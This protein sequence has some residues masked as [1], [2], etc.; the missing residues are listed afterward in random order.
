[1]L[2][3]GSGKDVLVGGAGEDSFVFTTT[4][5]SS[6]IDDIRDF[7]VADDTVELAARLYRLVAGALAATAFVIG[8]K[9]LTVDHR[10]IYDSAKGQLLFDADGAGGDKAVQF[11]KI[12][13]R[14]R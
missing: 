6:N 5:R 14:W 7:V 11:A 13:K 12:D 10:I 4:L 2:R 9:A 1:M 8:S 3:G